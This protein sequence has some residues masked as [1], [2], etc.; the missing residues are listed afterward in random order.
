MAKAHKF[1][2]NSSGSEIVIVLAHITKC[3]TDKFSE[4][5][6][7]TLTNGEKVGVSESLIDVVKAIENA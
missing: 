7:I 1:T 6:T 5:T 2:E 4:C 3:Q